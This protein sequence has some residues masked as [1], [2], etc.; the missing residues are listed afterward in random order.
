M[1]P[2]RIAIFASGSGSNFQAIVD[3]VQ[4]G[5]L[6]VSIELLV[7]DRPQAYVVERA[8]EAKVPVFAFRPKE[9]ANREAYE[10]LIL[11]EL[12]DRQVDLVVMAGYMRIITNVLVEPFFGRM[13]N[14]HPSLLPSF[15]GV[16]AIEQAVEYGVK[17]TGVTVHF[18]DGGLDSG[19]IIAQRAVEIHEHETAESLAERIHAAEHVLLPQVIRWLREGR[20]SMDGR[21][22]GIRL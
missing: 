6:D 8:Q 18:V 10:A 22:V 7:C 9:Y 21:R 5:K 2:Y 14:I 3:Q 4:K 17:Q 19:P 16:R 1:Q 11:K 15:P 13:I 20:V 12:Q